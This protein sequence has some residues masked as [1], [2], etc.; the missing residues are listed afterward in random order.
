MYEKRDHAFERAG[1]NIWEDCGKERERRN[2]NS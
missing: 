2:C 1:G